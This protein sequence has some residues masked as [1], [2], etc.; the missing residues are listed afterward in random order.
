ML[1][2]FP[3]IVSPQKKTLKEILLRH[4]DH[5]LPWSL[6]PHSVSRAAN[7]PIIPI[8]IILPLPLFV[9]ACRKLTL[10]FY[11]MGLSCCVRPILLFLFRASLI[12]L[13]YAKDKEIL[14]VIGRETHYSEDLSIENNLRDYVYQLPRDFK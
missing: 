13:N 7:V 10:F 6:F 8:K 5:H 2:V 3:E 1:I 9:K 12:T 11:N 4:S 14:A